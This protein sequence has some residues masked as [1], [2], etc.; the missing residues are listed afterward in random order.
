MATESSK[1]IKRLSTIF[2]KSQSELSSLIEPYLVLKIY[3]IKEA[4]IEL[5]KQLFDTIL[6]PL[7]PRP[8]AK[9]T[10]FFKMAIKEAMNN[11]PF[12]QQKKLR[13]P[14]TQ[15]PALFKSQQQ[16][17]YAM[18]K[19]ALVAAQTMLMPLYFFVSPEITSTQLTKDPE[20][21]RELDN[22][23]EIIITGTHVFKILEIL[24]QLSEK[25]MQSGLIE[26]DIIEKRNAF[27]ESL[28]ETPDTISLSEYTNDFND[29]YESWV[30]LVRN[31]SSI[32]KKAKTDFRQQL[33]AQL[34]Q[35]FNGPTGLKAE[36]YNDTTAFYLTLPKEE[37]FDYYPQADDKTPDLYLSAE[38]AASF[39]K[40]YPQ[41]QKCKNL[42][43]LIQTSCK[44]LR[45]KFKEQILK[46]VGDV[47]KMKERE[48]QPVELERDEI[49]DPVSFVRSF[50]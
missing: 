49:L 31:S 46:H 28:A 50:G 1:I 2:I 13:V 10:F 8:S 37:R 24:Y 4:Q 9:L 35:E 27:R 20:L 42:S 21:Q 12:N 25:T 40:D 18:S 15:E 7:M 19:I 5:I 43:D 38:L 26:H 16:R 6:A 44:L 47:K 17:F 39:K 14:L 45:E 3:P 36:I 22:F 34:L 48:K 23:K 29:C 41:L 11:P 33:I 30:A 32:G